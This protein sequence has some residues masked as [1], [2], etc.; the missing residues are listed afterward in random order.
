MERPSRESENTWRGTKEPT[1]R[2]VTQYGPSQVVANS[3]QVFEP[4]RALAC[5]VWSR[6]E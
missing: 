2:T 5:I 6:D 1:A 4:S 3:P